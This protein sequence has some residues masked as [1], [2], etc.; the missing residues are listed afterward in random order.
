[1]HNRSAPICSCF[2][3]KIKSLLSEDELQHLSEVAL[4]HQHQQH[5]HQGGA[6][7]QGAAAAATQQQRQH[8]QLPPPLQPELDGCWL[9]PRFK[10]VVWVV[11]DALRYDFA[12]FSPRD[13]DVEGVEAETKL[14]HSA[15]RDQLVVGFAYSSYGHVV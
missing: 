7:P 8:H 2:G 14:H 13:D 1:M 11:V 4:G 3:R 9:P 5:Q 15:G 10:R 12:A 6:S